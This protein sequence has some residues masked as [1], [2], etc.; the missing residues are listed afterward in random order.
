MIRLLLAVGLSSVLSLVLTRVLIVSLTRLQIGQPIREDGPQGHITKAGTPTMGGAAIVGG[1]FIAYM[2]S[3]FYNGIY[4]R[5]GL[6][7]MLTIV[8]AGIVGF[9]DDWIAISRERNM[10]L[11]KRAKS[12]GLLT[13]AVGFA[14]LMVTLT[15]VD[16]T[17]SFTR[18]DSPGW[19]IGPV[20][21]CVLAVLVILATSNA[22]NLTDGLDG[23]AAGSG[24]FLVQRLHSHC[25][26]GLPQRRDLRH[27]SRP[28]PGRRVCGDARRMPGIPLVERCARADLHG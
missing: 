7:V 25:V 12:I 16:T 1:A 10:G 19:D 18:S 24:V 3:D 13:V 23:L 14:V 4:T 20:G 21:W 11:N 5:T 17:I 27:R 15:E 22:V 8:G 9:L 6:I 26:L 2:V 28:R